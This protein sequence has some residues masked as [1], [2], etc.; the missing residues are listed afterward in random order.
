MLCETAIESERLKLSTCIRK[1]RYIS[2]RTHIWSSDIS[3]SLSLSLYENRHRH[4]CLPRVWVKL[5][6]FTNSTPVWVKEVNHSIIYVATTDGASTGLLLQ[7]ALLQIENNV[8]SIPNTKPKLAEGRIRWLFKKKLQGMLPQTKQKQ[9]EEMWGRKR[10]NISLKWPRNL[11]LT[12]MSTF[13]CLNGR[14]LSPHL[15]FT[16]FLRK[17][18]KSKTIVTSV[19]DCNVCRYRRV[20][21]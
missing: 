21:F 19:N 11:L 2:S 16:A 12:S 18:L 1:L 15:L 14:L 13:Y 17:Y 4:K 6:Y 10:N 3:L 20:L 5:I 7:S 9:A 8:K